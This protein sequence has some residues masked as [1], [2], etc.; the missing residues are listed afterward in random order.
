MSHTHAHRHTHTAASL[1]SV[2]LLLRKDALVDSADIDGDMPLHTACNAGSTALVKSFLSFGAS[3]SPVNNTGDTPMHVACRLGHVDI[4]RLLIEYECEMNGKN[5]Q[6][7]MPLGETR[8]GN[9]KK[10]VKLINE[11]FTDAPVR[12]SED[13]VELHL[14]KERKD[15]EREA[16]LEREVG[17]V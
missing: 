16:M 12:L 10:V 13:Q 3:P 8:T 9:A 1:S 11:F 6:G 2:L 17:A 14:W 15:K 5:F 7:R 4:A